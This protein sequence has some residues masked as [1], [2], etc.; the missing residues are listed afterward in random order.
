MS[1]DYSDS[2]RR[3]LP[4]LDAMASFM[5]QLKRMPGFNTLNGAAFIHAIDEARNIATKDFPVL[6]ND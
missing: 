3:A 6:R 5:I 1:A 4:Q 2:A